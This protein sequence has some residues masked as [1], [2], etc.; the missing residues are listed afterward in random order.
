MEIVFNPEDPY[1]DDHYPFRITSFVEEPLLE[2]KKMVDGVKIVVDHVHVMDQRNDRVYGYIA[3]DKRDCIVIAVPKVPYCYRHQFKHYQIRRS[4]HPTE[5]VHIGMARKEGAHHFN[6]TKERAME[7][8]ERLTKYFFIRFDEP[9]TAE[10]FP[11]NLRDTT[12][13]DIDPVFTT[14]KTM[15]MIEGIEYYDTWVT[16]EFIAAFPSTLSEVKGDDKPSAK[17][18]NKYAYKNDDVVVE[19]T[20]AAMGGEY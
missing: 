20:D 8:D 14:V 10:H 5:P 16:M 13:D 15:Y 19:D 7:V 9:L 2:G 12:G 18:A 6:L 11:F 3:G 1:D 4:E 17:K